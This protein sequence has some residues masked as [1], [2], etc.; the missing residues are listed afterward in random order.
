MRRCV[1]QYSNEAANFVGPEGL[2]SPN[3]LALGLL[4]PQVS[5]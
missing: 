3:I 2:E 1:V 5:Q 4:Q